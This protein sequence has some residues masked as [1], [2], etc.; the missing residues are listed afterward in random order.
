[1]VVPPLH[2]AYPTWLRSTGHSV[3]SAV[4]RVGAMAAPYLV[5]SNAQQHRPLTVPAVLTAV[6]LVRGESGINPH[7]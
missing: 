4:A 7:R 3:A 6:N 1:V 5:Y 2:Q